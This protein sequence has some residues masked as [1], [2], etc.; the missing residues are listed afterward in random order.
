MERNLKVGTVSALTV[1]ALAMAMAAAYGQPSSWASTET[2]VYAQGDATRLANLLDIESVPIVVSLKLRNQP[3]LESVA[4][5]V[6]AGITERLTRETY[7]ANHAPTETQVQ[8]VVSYLSTT[9]YTNIHVDD[10]RLLISADGTAGTARAAFQTHLSRFERAGHQGIANIDE[11]KVPSDLADIVLAVVG[12]QTVEGPH[13]QV[14]A[15]PAGIVPPTGVVGH[16]PTEF[17]LIYGATSLPTATTAPVGIIATG[18]LTNVLADLLHFQTLNGLPVITP[19]V[20]TVGTPGTSTLEDTE[21]DLD[22]QAM[23]GMARSFAS[24]TFYVG[25]DLND[26]S[27]LS[28][29]STAV[30]QNT[31]RIVNV[32]IGE[33]ES[34][35]VSNGTLASGDQIFMVG[36]A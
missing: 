3:Q 29:Y 36:A 17:P 2:H 6:M 31:A 19:S 18:S 28:A 12:L 26:A 24:L 30:S 16:N 14:T 13:T 32:S 34:V 21:W 15:P 27:L 25:N 5:G 9:G 7:M 11:V 22:S 1:G 10:N 35:A 33:C 23:Q 4:H 20:V 8:A